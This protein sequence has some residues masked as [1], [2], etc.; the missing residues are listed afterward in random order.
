[1]TNFGKTIFGSVFGSLLA[2]SGCGAPT[3][4]KEGIAEQP[5]VIEEIAVAGFDPDGEPV[6]KKWSDGTISIQF[7]AMPPFFAEDEGTEE[8]FEN[9]ESKI[10]ESLGVDVRRDDRELFVIEKPNPDTAEKAKAW[11]ESHRSLG[12]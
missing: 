3:D 1:M 6:I 7:E 8:E 12:T 11:L 4:P 9:F 5:S 10:Q 2:M